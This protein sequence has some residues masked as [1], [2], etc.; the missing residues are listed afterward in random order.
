MIRAATLLLGSNLGVALLRFA[1]NIMLAR[2]LS[3]ENFGIA[4]TFAMTFALLEM[5]G[6][7]GLDRLLVQT[8]D[9]DAPRVQATLHSIQVL[10]G[11]LMALLLYFTAAPLAGFMGVP[12]VAWGFQLMAVIPLIQGL[13]HL[14]IARAQRGMNFGPFM[15]TALATECVTLL[16]IWPLYLAFGD[17]RVAL[18][19][20]IFQE[21]VLLVLSHLVAERAFRFGLDRD[22]AI[23]AFHFG[24]PLLL[25]AFLMYG[26]FQGDRLIVANRLG[27]TE[28]GLFSLAFVLTLVPSKVMAQTQQLLFLPG[29]ARLKD[30]DAAFRR[31]AAVAVQAGLAAGLVLAA[32]FSVFGPDLVLAL[33]GDKYAGSLAVLV[34]LA[35]M[36]AARIAK[37]GVSVAALARGETRNPMIAN[38]TRILLLP[39]AWLAVGSG[40]D[41]VVVVWLA[42]LG[43]LLGVGVALVLLDRWVGVPIAVFARPVAAWGLALAVIC[44]VLLEAPVE[45]RPFANLAWP[46]LAVIAAAAVALLSMTD[47]RSWV[48]SHLSGH[49]RGAG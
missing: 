33:F 22:L 3:V 41:L 7:L 27:A 20:L 2:L 34:W 40:A 44:A 25:N 9:G 42:I 16:M 32:G 1:R 6:Y 46:Q 24:W 30:D 37:S 18:F 43:E 49:G 19:A 5:V 8:N 12:E 10:R 35:V 48:R 28:L 13:M 38:I 47:L 23:R 29:L 26:I 21:S 17:Y 31:L 36:Q 45:P 4:S 11:V 14:D 15:K 39:A